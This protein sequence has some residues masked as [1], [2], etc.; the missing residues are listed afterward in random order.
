MTVGYLISHKLPKARC[1]LYGNWN[2]KR[3]VY[4]LREALFR[5]EESWPLRMPDLLTVNPEQVNKGWL[6]PWRKTKQGKDDGFAIW[7][8]G[9]GDY[10]LPLWWGNINALGS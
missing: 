9:D 8:L 6:V 10:R 4:R 5:L 3:N 7:S 1:A 2:K